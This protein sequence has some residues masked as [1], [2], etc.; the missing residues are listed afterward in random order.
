METTRMEA[1]ISDLNNYKESKLTK[2]DIIESIEYKLT[3]NNFN[4]EKFSPNL[5]LSKLKYRMKHYHLEQKLNNDVL[6]L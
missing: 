5:F 6:E 2:S 1:K 3:S 4:P